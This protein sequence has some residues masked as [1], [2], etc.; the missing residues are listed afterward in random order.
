MVCL[1]WNIPDIWF[2][3]ES[4]GFV[5]TKYTI[6][7]NVMIPVKKKGLKTAW[8]ILHQHLIPGIVVALPNEA[9]C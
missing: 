9:L 8:A 3:Y 2:N 4:V 7:Q 6:K 1:Y 5:A